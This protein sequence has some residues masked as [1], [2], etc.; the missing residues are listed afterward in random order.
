[1]DH[2]SIITYKRN[3]HHN[4][5]KC[6]SV[7]PTATYKNKIKKHAEIKIMHFYSSDVMADKISNVSQNNRIELTCHHYLF[8][9]LGETAYNS[10]FIYLNIFSRICSTP[11][12]FITFWWKFAP[13][14]QIFS[15]NFW[16]KRTP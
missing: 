3:K 15:A 14:Q 6:N 5:Y 10:P 9:Q 4:N 2:P 13:E 1:M 8:G 11:E 12:Y 16:I 7:I